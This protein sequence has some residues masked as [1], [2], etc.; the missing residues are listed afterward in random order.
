MKKTLLKLK[1]KLQILIAA[2]LIASPL[3]ILSSCSTA[4]QKLAPSAEGF[5]PQ[6]FSSD[7]YYEE[8]SKSFKLKSD[9]YLLSPQTVRLD[10]R[11]Q[12]DLPVASFVMSDAKLEYILYRSK[13]YFAGKPG[14][15]A[16]DAIIP[17]DISAEELVAVILEKPLKS[18][19]CEYENKVLTRCHGSAGPTSYNV[20]WEK[21]VSSSP[22]SGK[23]TKM[24]IEIPQR[25]ISL[26]FYFSDWTK[27]LSNLEQ[28]SSVRIPD[29]FHK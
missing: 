25:K 13:K 17:L 20:L 2:S 28:L 19:K 9:I 1:I 29:D 10:V 15:H 22:W 23:A 24:V 3:L 26:R 16:L 4:P 8:G 27:K 6:G 21:R 12:L 18:Q 5:A 11:T 14:T 7:V